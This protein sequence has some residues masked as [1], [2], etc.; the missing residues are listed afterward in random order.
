MPWKEDQKGIG[1]HRQTIEE[2]PREEKKAIIKR[3]S[4]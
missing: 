2:G 1:L 3:K 4:N